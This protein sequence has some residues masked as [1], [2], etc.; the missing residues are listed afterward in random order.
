MAS[1]LAPTAHFPLWQHASPL[2]PASSSTP[3]RC[4]CGSHQV[5]ARG[6][7]VK[8]R[9]SGSFYSGAPCPPMVVRRTVADARNASY[10]ARRLRGRGIREGAGSC[11]LRH[12]GPTPI[13]TVKTRLCGEEAWVRGGREIG[14]GESQQVGPRCRWQRRREG[15]GRAGVSGALGRLA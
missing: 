10:G 13:T 12:P 2:S 14:E 3:V 5:T 11:L 15:E 4:A 6:I 1:S 9:A 7:W 8:A